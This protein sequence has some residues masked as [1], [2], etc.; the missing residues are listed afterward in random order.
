MRQP[1]VCWRQSGCDGDF[2]STVEHFVTKVARMEWQEKAAWILQTAT[3]WPLLVKLVLEKVHDQ[4]CAA[5]R[6]RRRASREPWVPP[7]DPPPIYNPPQELEMVY[8]FAIALPD[9]PLS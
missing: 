2:D 9:G 1:R 7:N 3:Y 8:P 4:Q 5:S 6:A